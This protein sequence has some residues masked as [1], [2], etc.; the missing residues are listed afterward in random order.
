M[1][2]RVQRGFLE[3]CP[4]PGQFFT[5]VSSEHHRRGETATVKTSGFEFFCGGIRKNTYS[6]KHLATLNIRQCNLEYK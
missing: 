4:S 5:G 2:Q 6:S 1:A 3:S